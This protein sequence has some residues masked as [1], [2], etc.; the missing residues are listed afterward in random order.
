MIES[1]CILPQHIAT[2]PLAPQ[3]RRL[4]FRGTYNT[5][6]QQYMPDYWERAAVHLEMDDHLFTPIFHACTQLT[7][8]DVDQ[9]PFQADEEHFC[10]DR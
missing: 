7:H 8:L 5:M 4:S 1:L 10:P 3:L 2:S 6:I 9:A